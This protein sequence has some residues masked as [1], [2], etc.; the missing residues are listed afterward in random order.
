[1]SAISPVISKNSDRTNKLHH[2]GHGQKTDG[3]IK[4][5]R[6]TFADDSGAISP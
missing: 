6:T 2:G 5:A 3:I 1:M 4:A